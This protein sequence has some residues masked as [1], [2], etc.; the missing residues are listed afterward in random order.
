MCNTFE[1]A[2]N[3]GEG[4]RGSFPHGLSIS[5][6]IQKPVVNTNMEELAQELEGLAHTQVSREQ[7]PHEAGRSQGKAQGA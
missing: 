5:F 7:R 6:Q 3:S 1:K 2:G 4:S